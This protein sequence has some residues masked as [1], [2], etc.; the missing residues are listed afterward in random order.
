MKKLLGIASV[1]ALMVGL[2]VAPAQ[3]QNYIEGSAGVTTQDSLEWGGA[4]YDM[5][6]GWNAA[7]S[8][9]R[10]M[11]TNW[12]VEAEFSYDEM[13]YSCCNPNNTH[14]YRLMANAT[15]NFTT[16]GFVPYLGGGV[17]ASWVTYEAG[18]FEAEGT[19]IAYQLIGGIR[20]PVGPAWSIF[21]E[22]RYQDT[23]ED[24]EDSGLE[25]EHAG[26]NFAIGARFN[27]N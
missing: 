12:D 8:V 14:E 6:D 22:Y 19:V 4:D 11:W 23:F 7:I 10:S 16:G 25:W 3:A 15:Y 9:G 2:S 21:G 18:G 17:G 13:E 5:D 27:L 24:A 26:N 20:V 1:A